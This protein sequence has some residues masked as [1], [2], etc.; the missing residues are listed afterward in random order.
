[1]ETGFRCRAM[2][3][4]FWTWFTTLL[5]E[6]RSQ[7]LKGVYMMDG[8]SWKSIT[9]IEESANF[10]IPDIEVP[11]Q[12]T[13]CVRY[14]LE[15]ENG[16]GWLMIWTKKLP[17]CSICPGIQLWANVDK[18]KFG[19]MD[20]DSFELTEGT[21]EYRENVIRKWNSMCWSFDF[22]EANHTLQVSCVRRSKNKKRKKHLQVSCVKKKTP[23]RSPGMVA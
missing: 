12:L 22:R 18:P 21:L 7:T 6:R 8:R 16:G 5:L 23:S 10:Y 4:L 19:I 17:I 2:A 15:F 20:A 14:Y 11:V 13:V 9:T 3:W 1:M